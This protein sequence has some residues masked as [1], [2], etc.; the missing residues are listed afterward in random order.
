MQGRS[1]LHGDGSAGNGA[2]DRTFSG[3]VFPCFLSQR[4]GCCQRSGSDNGGPQR[5][6]W[7]CGRC[8][9]ATSQTKSAS[10]EDGG[11]ELVVRRDVGIHSGPNRTKLSFEY[12]RS[13]YL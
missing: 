10:Y 5:G 12:H 13:Q 2:A 7:N 1:R 4:G 6:R 11:L 8:K 3:L 9:L